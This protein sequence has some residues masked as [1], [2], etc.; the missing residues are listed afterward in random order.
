[1]LYAWVDGTKRAPL[2]KGETTI[3]QDCGGALTSVIPV[4]NIKHWRHKAGDCDN[5]SEPEGKWH[6]SWKEHF[7]FDSREICLMD[8][9]SGEKHRADILCGLGTSKSTVLELQHSNISE[10][11][12]IARE[13]FYSQNNQ[14]FWLIHIHSETSFNEFS[15]ESAISLSSEVNYTGR[16]FMKTTWTGRSYQFIEK[17]KRS[18]VDVF[19]DW[20]G[21]IFYLANEKVSKHLGSP[22]G[23]GEFAVC[24]LSKREFID[25]VNGEKRK[26][27][28]EIF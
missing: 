28:T 25:A 11:E 9:K 17:W 13:L 4:E 19:F 20:K 16:K 12:R 27:K 15:F 6:L 8:E 23:R 26:S 7:D 2:E 18:S 3:C 21:Y 1:M 5:W 22:F 14:M 24:A 10:E